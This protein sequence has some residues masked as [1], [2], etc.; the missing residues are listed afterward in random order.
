MTAKKPPNKIVWAA[1]CLVA[2]P[3]FTIVCLAHIAYCAAAAKL[4]ETINH[5]ARHGA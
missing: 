2:L 1:F 4:R 3:L 5:R